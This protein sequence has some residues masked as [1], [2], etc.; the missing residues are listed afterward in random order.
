MHDF[1]L[2][3]LSG[4]AFSPLFELPDTEL[5]RRGMQRCIAEEDGGWPCRVSLQDAAR[6]DELL[7]LSFEHQPA[8][9]PYRASGPI[10]VRR[11]A[12]QRRPPANEVPPYLSTRLLSVRAYDAADMIVGACVR[13]GA[14]VAEEID[15]FFD[16]P[17]VAYLHLHFAKRGC[18]ACRVERA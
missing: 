6:G 17:A 14:Q 4:T 2:V 5:A 12:S 1:R 18:F 10:F 15:R 3:A 13:D 9:S 7:L 11:G 16:D 8:V